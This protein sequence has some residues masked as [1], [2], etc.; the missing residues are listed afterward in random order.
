M[1]DLCDRIGAAFHID[2]VAFEDQIGQVDPGDPNALARL[3]D[4]MG[5]P[6]VIL[7]AITSP[8]QHALRPQLEAL[9]AVVAGVVDH[10]LDEVGAKL[11]PSS[12][13]LTEALRRRRVE[14]A[15]SARLVESLL[16]LDLA[17]PTSDSSAASVDVV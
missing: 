13:L 12:P 3:Q 7:G 15:E 4:L 11:I 1:Y 5:S 2:P 9:V 8:A 17:Q 6:D 16:V 14:A 10:V